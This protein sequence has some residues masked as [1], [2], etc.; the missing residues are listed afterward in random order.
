MALSRDGRTAATGSWDGTARVWDVPTRKPIG[1]PLDHGGRV[2]SVALSPDGTLVLTSSTNGTTQ[3]WTAG[4]R[5]GKWTPGVRQRAVGAPLSPGNTVTAMAF[6]PDGRSFI[7]GIGAR[8]ARIWR[9][10]TAVTDPA[11]RLGPWI[12]VI[13]R[14]ELLSSGEIRSIDLEHWWKD[15]VELISH[16]GLLDGP[17]AGGVTVSPPR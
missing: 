5:P 3:L 11:D 9:T 8:T 16:G 10:P 14:K 15:R 1:L 4:V 13:T 12:R 17:T 7:T 2:M 6:S